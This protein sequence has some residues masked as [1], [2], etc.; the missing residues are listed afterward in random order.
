MD[1]QNDRSDLEDNRATRRRKLGELAEGST[2]RR[3]GIDRLE[4]GSGSLDA[5]RER[6]VHTDAGSHRRHL[7]I[8]GVEQQDSLRQQIR[9]DVRE[10][11]HAQQLVGLRVHHELDEA[12]SLAHR[13][14]PRHALQR[15]LADLHLAT[16]SDRF[17]LGDADAG[18]LRIGEH[19]PGNAAGLVMLPF[20]LERIGDRDARRV[21]G[22]VRVLHPPDHVADRPDVPGARLQRL[23]DLDAVFAAS[24]DTGLAEIHVREL[25]RPAPCR[26]QN[27]LA[28]DALGPPLDLGPDGERSVRCPLDALGPRGGADVEAFLAQDA[29]QLARDLLVLPGQH[30]LAAL[31]DR[32]EHAE[33]MEHLRELHSLRAAADD[34]HRAREFLHIHHRLVGLETRLAQAED[35]RHHRHDPGGD[36]DALR[37]HRAAV[38]LDALR[39]EEPR[40]A[41]HKLDAGVLLQR[42][43]EVPDDGGDQRVLARADPR[44]VHFESGDAEAELFASPRHLDRL[45]RP[46]LG[47]DWRNRG[48]G[49]ALLAALR[50]RTDLAFEN[51]ALRQQLALLRRRSKRPRFG[52]LDRA[53]WVWLSN[54]W[55]GGRGALHVVRPET[56]IRWHRQGFR[57]FWTWKSRRGRTGRPPVGSEPA[58]LVRTMALANPLWGAP[59]IT[60]SCSS[61]GSTSRSLALPDSCPAASS[62]PRSRGER[63]SIT[64]SATSPRLTSSSYRRRPSACSTCSWSCCIIAAGSR[65][66]T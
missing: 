35:V 16:S 37:L 30:P 45:R 18:D 33:A 13:A 52:R 43:L 55:A 21:G 54:Q 41:A 11:V 40:A 10:H 39:S 4:A 38:H 65:T 7:P 34:D 47:L 20:V 25:V 2:R 50:T 57:A 48:K 32:D 61:S 60:A 12:R 5:L 66:S 24:L 23:V 22:E 6:R 59:R 42:A 64:T 63:S 53:F 31:Q 19:R 46:N 9:P 44:P 56:V 62:H 58:E 15:L 49:C 36:D 17:A 27:L 28:L 1:L 29:F 51:L 8:G 26:N 14:R 3:H